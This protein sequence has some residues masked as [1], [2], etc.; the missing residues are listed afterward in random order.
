MMKIGDK[1]ENKE[2]LLTGNKQAHLHD[3]LGKNL[4]IYFY[5]KAN[6]PGC[7][8]ES[9]DFNE[10]FTDFQKNNT[11][12]LG[13]SKDTLKRQE[14]FKEKYGFAFDLVADEAEELCHYFDVIKEKKNYGRTY[15]GIVRSTFLFNAKGQLIQEWRNVRV[16]NHA[17]AV[18]D[19]VK[20]I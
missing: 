9:N 10:L 19:A 17:Q 6:T 2:I 7:T 16:K 15:M 1:I 18:F 12:I 3:Y 14:N 13:V 20:N 5:P 4:I 8:T 11:N